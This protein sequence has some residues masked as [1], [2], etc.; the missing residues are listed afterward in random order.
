MKLR[1][2][3]DQEH[4][5][6][7]AGQ[8]A[9]PKGVEF[10]D[11]VAPKVYFWLNEVAKTVKGLRVYA[12][13]NEMLQKYLSQSYQGLTD[14]LEQM[15]ELSLAVREDRFLF[16]KEAVHISEDRSEGLPFIFYRN[17]F[18]R[19]TFVKGMTREELLSLL[20]A[21]TTDYSTFDYAGEDLVTALWRLALPHLRYLTIDAIH[22]EAKNANST[23]AREEIDRIQGDIESIVA[24]IYNTA[25]SDE[26]IVAGVTITKEDLEA[27]KDIRKESEEDLE[28]LDHATARAITDIPAE[29]IARVSRELAR[30]DRDQLTR[31]TMDILIGILFRETSSKGTKDVIEVLQ[32]LFDSLVLGQRFT[33][34]TKLLQ[35]L[36]ERASHAEDMQEMHIAR[37]LLK[38]F[39]AES[40]VLPI[41]SA[42]GEGYK[43]ATIAEVTEF[44]RALGSDITPLLVRALD[45]LGNPAHRR[46]LCDLIVEFGIPE[47]AELLDAVQDSKWFVVR[48]VLTLAQR[49]PPETIGPLIGFA[50]QHQ[51]PKVRSHAVGMLRH[52]ARGAAD[53]FLAAR[54]N[55]DPDLEVRLAAVRVAAA[56]SSEE[57]KPILERMLSRED[58]HHREPRE[59]RMLTAAYAKIAG[60]EAVSVLDK[61]LNPGFFASL[62]S[63][64]AQIAAAYALGAVGTESAIVALEKGARSINGKVREAVKKALSRGE[65]TGDLLG[66]APESGSK[67]PTG[68]LPRRIPDAKTESDPKRGR[69]VPIP[70]ALDDR[71]KKQAPDLEFQVRSAKKPKTVDLQE[72]GPASLHIERPQFARE[73]V[74][75]LDRLPKLPTDLPLVSEETPE[76]DPIELEP[77][78]IIL[79]L[80]EASEASTDETRPN[81]PLTDDLILE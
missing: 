20:K 49:L 71:K 40:R 24:A 46:L 28:V 39:A 41:L 79:S 14:L 78:D 63:T 48:D 9:L 62:T 7:S 15:G 72:S 53:R 54:M 70:D 38:L 19:L 6:G 67:A 13:N 29:Q 22:L 10:K 74:P 33:H 18:R 43:T 58:L 80:D 8:P 81:S 77:E 61:I 55:L 27:L 42:L 45:G 37:H 65:V 68:D 47:V 36:R 25:A 31:E 44:L 60:S 5:P 32:Q 56:R 30:E 35:L 34:A 21:I 26:D 76:P 69:M 51:H 23:E 12:E 11:P 2:V 73:V 64:E 52:Y 50:I 75:N 59:I 16:G 17:A 66:D 1:F 57:A 3:S 4:T